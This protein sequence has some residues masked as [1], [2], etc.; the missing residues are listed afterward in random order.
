MNNYPSGAANDPRAPYNESLKKQVKVEVS[1]DL[2]TMVD[3]EVNCE[4]GYVDEEDLY[5]EVRQE[6]IKKYNIDNNDTI[7]DNINIW[8]W[9]FI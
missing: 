7:L 3:V 6:L 2:G 5:W 8:D 4:D 1:I 9:R